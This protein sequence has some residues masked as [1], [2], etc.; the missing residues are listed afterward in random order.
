MIIGYRKW[1]IEPAQHV[2]K[3]ISNNLINLT[4]YQIKLQELFPWQDYKG[5]C[6]AVMEWVLEQV[7]VANTLL[8][9]IVIVFLHQLWVIYDMWNMPPGP[10]LT[11]IPFVGNLL[12]FDPGNAVEGRAAIAEHTRRSVSICLY[13]SIWRVDSTLVGCLVR[14]S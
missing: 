12:S 13:N 6:Y 3:R 5:I 14:Q 11:S 1:P 9:F 10:R 2:D 7:T 4:D 8:V